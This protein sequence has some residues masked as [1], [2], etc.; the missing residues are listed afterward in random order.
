V[1]LLPNLGDIPQAQY[2][3]IVQAFPGATAAEKQQNYLNWLT[4]RIL[5]R[6]EEFQQLKAQKA[7]HSQLP[8]RPTDPAQ[9]IP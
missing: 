7:I 9:V 6:V 3:L 4:C 5:D 8:A 1:P 2:D